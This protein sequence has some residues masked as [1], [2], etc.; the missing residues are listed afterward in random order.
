LKSGTYKLLYLS[1]FLIFIVSC[2]TQREI[3]GMEDLAQADISVEELMDMIPDYRNELTT[4][5]GSG[6]ALVSE[7]GNSERV[8]IQFQSN[9]RESLILVRNNVG[10]EGGQ[11]YV[12]SDSLLIYNRLDRKAEKIPLREGRLSSVGSIAS[13]NIL[14]LVNYTLNSTDIYEIFEDRNYYTVIL[15]NRSRITVN[16][17]DGL[18]YEVVHTTDYFDAPY[19]K[20]EY[21]GYARINGFLLPRRITIYSRDETSKATLLVQRLEVNMELP[22]LSI[23]IPDDIPILRI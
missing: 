2:S 10:I 11:I 23:S 4:I 17:T 15:Q 3:A 6:R 13:I 12:D 5:S 18:I 7:P 21:A 9:R 22:E 19:S 1:V 20:I 16:K 8:T 14:D